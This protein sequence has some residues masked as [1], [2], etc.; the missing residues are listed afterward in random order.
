M[1]A[2]INRIIHILQ[3]IFSI[4][5]YISNI[6]YYKNKSIFFI[7]F[8]KNINALIEVRTQ[9]LRLIRPTL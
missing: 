7:K 8:I 1:K 3:K 4:N 9:D 6:F 2:K 5:N